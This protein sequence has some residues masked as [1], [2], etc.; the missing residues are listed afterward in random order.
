MDADGL[1]ARR[2][3]R[4]V[5]SDSQPAW[6]PDG[7]WL[8]F[9]SNRSGHGEIYRIRST[10][11]YGTPIRLT[12]T[13]QPSTDDGFTFNAMPAWSPD[14]RR[15]AFS[16]I[17]GSS[18][19][20]GAEVVKLGIMRADGTRTRVKNRYTSEGRMLYAAGPSWG[21][22]GRYLAWAHDRVYVDDPPTNVYRSTPLGSTALEVTRYPESEYGDTCCLG[23]PTWSPWYGKWIVYSLT[24]FG[25]TAPAIY[26][27]A[28]NGT[29][30]P[31]LVARNA[32]DPDWG[33]ALR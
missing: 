5:A 15:I 20:A 8:A 6:S 12:F 26:R 22:G 30:A 4:N 29:G 7:R 10:R 33:V 32:Q 13:E 24:P 17:W 16:R 18:T 1:G 11:P 19:Y 27:V 28:S 25:A 3:T 2:V 14:G 9:T 21:P 31:T 23:G